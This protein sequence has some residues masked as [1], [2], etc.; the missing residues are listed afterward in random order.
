MGPERHVFDDMTPEMLR[1]RGT[2]KWCHHDA[3]VLNFWIAEMDFRAAPAVR[4]AAL[5]AV[6]REEFGYPLPDKASGLP[7]AVAEWQAQRYG[8]KIAR[9]NVHVLP[10]VL[11]GLELGI[12][13]FSPTGSAVIVPTPAYPPFFMVPGVVNRP[14]IAVP[15]VPDG[16]R[17]ALDLE[18]IDEAFAAGAGT[19]VLCNPHN[20]LGRVFT[21]DELLA[22]CDIVERHGGRVVADEIH[23]PLTYPGYQ[24]IPYASISDRSARHCL[25]L[26]SPGKGW[27]L[28]GLKCAAAITSCEV[29]EERWRS[30][31]AMK[32]HGASTIGIRTATAAFRH[33]GPWLDDVLTY[34]DRNRMLLAE[35]LRAHL[36]E[37]GYTPPEGTYL[38]WLDC[39]RL[40]LGDEVAAFFLERARVGTN[41][42]SAFGDN[43][44]GHIRFNFATSHSI[45]EQGIEAMTAAVRYGARGER[46]PA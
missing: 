38:A 26:V 17:W 28:P 42:G 10:D 27:N 22:L 37:V 43:G 7:A 9:E 24:H 44:R 46:P 21:R 8:W 23:A 45:L 32:T 20:P 30:L 2:V 4:A 25:T 13:R 36:P 39:R 33:G 15:M 34:L 1:R 29:D 3:D 18:S 11:K 41:P 12:E 31:T 6:E 35:L 5:D 40:G 19:I 16:G 14:V